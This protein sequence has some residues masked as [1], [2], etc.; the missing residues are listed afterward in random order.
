M[1]IDAS[2]TESWRRALEVFSRVDVCQS[3]Q[4]HVAYSRRI[5]GSK[6]LLWRYEK[7]GESFCYPFLLTP[8]AQ[9]TDYHDISSIYGYS[10]PLATT[11]NA[12]FLQAAWAAFD[13][14]TAERKVIA[15]FTRFSPYA[16]SKAFAHP[17]ATV[18]ANRTIAVSRL[19]RNEEE[20]L[21]ALGAKTRNMLRRAEKSGLQARQLAAKEWIG[22]FRTLYEETMQR[23]ESPE[24]FLYDDAYYDTLLSLPE[25]EFRLFGVF[26]G[27]KLVSAAIA[28]TAG[29]GALYHLGA[30]LAEYAHNGA[31]NLCLFEMSKN[32]MTDGVSFLNVGGGRT[33]DPD[34]PL[35]RFKKSNA[36]A[37]ETFYIGKR[38]V[39]AGGY[40]D[41]TRLW[42]A[43]TGKDIDA[44]K[45]IFYR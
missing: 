45:L 11:S 42:K 28:L 8:V 17:D 24:F 22:A 43:A 7:A 37:T 3:P 39:D 38:I 9:R 27:E 30:G 41:V 18:E 5:A 29:Q 32:L 26:H 14:W 33:T 40:R 35:L 36:M 19:P 21:Q 4:Y 1:I 12:D 6:P 2:D 16:G 25:G 15:E 23:N 13:A 34:D 10:G 20:L 44:S 31:G